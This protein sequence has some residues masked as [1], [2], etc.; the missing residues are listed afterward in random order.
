MFFS[1]VLFSQILFGKKNSS[2]CSRG[3]E[4]GGRIIEFTRTNLI[5][6][7]IDWTITILYDF[8]CN[9]Y[10]SLKIC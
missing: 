10:I 5:L 6:N 7:I 3:L 9:A 2:K 1:D 4:F 8:T